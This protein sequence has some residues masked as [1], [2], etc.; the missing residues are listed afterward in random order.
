LL[1][2]LGGDRR[3]IGEN[4]R[5]AATLDLA[6]LSQRLGQIIGAVHGVCLCESEDV[7]V[8]VYEKMFPDGDRVQILASAI[9]E[10]D[11][12]DPDVT[13]RVWNAVSNRFQEQARD[14][15]MNSE[16]PNFAA[17]IVE[18]AM[19]AGYGDEDVAALV[20]VLRNR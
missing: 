2:C 14:A 3:Y 4:I 7:G 5:A 13:V 17:G 9:R 8:D 16:F 6:W 1:E 19:G 11:Y 18:R 12:I 20:K 15:G 10:D